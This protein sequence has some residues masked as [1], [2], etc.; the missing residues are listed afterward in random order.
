[1][2]ENILIASHNWATRTPDE[3]FWDVNEFETTM[4]DRESR[5]SEIKTTVQK[6]TFI[7]NG[8]GDDADL[9]VQIRTPDG[10]IAAE[11][12][13][14][15]FT[16]M[17]RRLEY[18]TRGLDP[19]LLSVQTIAQIL[20]ER[21]ERIDPET[22][23]LLLTQMEDGGRTTIKSVTSDAYARLN[24][25]ACVP[26][27]RK[28]IDDWGYRLP[29]ARPTGMPGERVRIATEE[30]VLRNNN[31][32]G[33]ASVEVGDLMAPAGLYGGDE[34]I[35]AL[36]VNDKDMVDQGNGQSLMSG[37]MIRN[38]SVGVGSYT[39]TTFNMQ[40]I[41][42]NHVIWSAENVVDITYRHIGEAVERIYKAMANLVPSNDQERL[43]H[44]RT[45]MQ[46]MSRNYLGGN[47]TEVIESVRHSLSRKHP[48]LTEK[49][50]FMAYANA[51][52]YRTEDGDPTTYLGMMN[53]LTR[54]SQTIPYQNVRKEID[55]AA[56]Q[57]LSLAEKNMA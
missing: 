5:Q 9:G 25:S 10:M 51:E 4:K 50:M 19:E 18:P 13:N 43:D 7:A 20:N 34:D 40:G 32:G 16:Q 23:L 35:F 49:L 31:I 24:N 12:N 30:D 44:M 15:S 42:G 3:R 11:M 29:P 46:W 36:M 55:K 52:Q 21:V 57:L 17:A 8:D 41:C 22:S 33:G 47:A 26:F 2:S 39:C 28:I 6:V 53:A 48:V 54:F 45:I 38:S 14:L 37:I 56:S 27:L 1:M